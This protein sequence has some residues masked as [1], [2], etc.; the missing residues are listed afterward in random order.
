M[1]FNLWRPLGEDRKGFQSSTTSL[2]INGFLIMVLEAYFLISWANRITIPSSFTIIVT[3]NKI[4]QR[5]MRKG[6]CKVVTGNPKPVT[7]HITI[8]VL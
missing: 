3:N 2:N 8:V 5:K 1:D 7:T 6:S 4:L